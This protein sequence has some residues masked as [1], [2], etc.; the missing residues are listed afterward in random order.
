[1]GVTAVRGRLAIPFWHCWNW[2]NR[3]PSSVERTLLSTT[4]RWFSK[5]KIWEPTQNQRRRTG[6]SAPHGL[7]LNLF[8]PA[9]AVRFSS[10][11]P[12]A[13]AVGCILTP[14]RG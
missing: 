4:W 1:M 3:S 10:S 14:L 11:Y 7:L 13:C 5:R 6:V 8:R 12:T 9:G 2:T